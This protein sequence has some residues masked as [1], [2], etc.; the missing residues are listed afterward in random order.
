FPILLPTAVKLLGDGVVQRFIVGDDAIWGGDCTVAPIPTGVGFFALEDLFLDAM[1][2][3]WP[4]SSLNDIAV[5]QYTGGTTGMPKGAMLT[6]ANLT[7]AVSMFHAITPMPEFKAGS[8]RVICVAPLFHIIG[9]SGIMLSHLAWGNEIVLFAK[10]D[11]ATL[12]E[13]IEV[14]KATILLAVP[15]IWI[16]IANLPNIEERDLSSL[17]DARSGGAPMP[18][19]VQKR[20][21]N[22][23]GRQILGGW[24]MTETSPTGTRLVPGERGPAGLIGIPYPGIDLRIVSLEDPER[25]LGIGEVGE[26]AV[27]GPNVFR[28]YWKKPE[29]TEEAFVNGFFLTG[30]IGTMD[31]KGQFRIVD[32]KKNMIISSGF[33]VYPSAIENAIYDHPDVK[34]TIV[35]GVPDDYRGQAAKAFIVLKDGRPEMTLEDLRAFLKDRIGRHEMPTAI[36]FRNSL[37]RSPAGKLLAKVLIEEEKARCLV[38]ESDGSGS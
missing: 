32:R 29:A 26:I 13:E 24:G 2:E 14:K 5:L 16:A 23:L 1:E 35:I 28:G 18:E 8:E 31:E 33:N 22:M 19:E 15:T 27:R 30:D 11:A 3:A 25:F 20:L 4:E 37:P 9:L 21:E 10:F 12:V 34:E 17:K 38:P 6:H 7:A 36:E